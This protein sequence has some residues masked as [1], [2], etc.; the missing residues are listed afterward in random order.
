MH[1]EQVT[2]AVAHH[3]EGPVWISGTRWPDGLYWVDML[4][5]D[6]LSLGPSGRVARRKVGEVVAVV[7]PRVNGGLA[8]AIERGFALD[9]GPGTP[10]RRLPEL[11]SDR[12]VRMNEGGCDP[13][14]FFYAGSMAYD[15]RPA[16]GALYRLALNGTTDLVEGG[17]T[18]PNGL[19][20]AP[21]GRTAYHA[22]TVN[23]RID[24]W[25]WDA[26]AG[27]HHRRPWVRV[28]ANGRPDGLTVDSEGGVW[29]A[30]SGASCVHRYSP[31]GTLSEVIDV[32]AAQVSACA[33]GG[34]AR[35]ELFITTSREGLADPE[36]AAG[37]LFHLHTPV[38]GVAPH[39]YGG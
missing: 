1:A 15:G 9:D 20:W 34:A 27:L 30:I 18:I 38:R 16:A 2:P 31:D 5:G 11:W 6:V 26:E 21:D 3:G 39:P 33:F 17:W 28:D 13:A 22:D 35:D 37:A 32:P 10:L 14:G 12:G 8:Y 25:D 36:P 29:V 4:V 23:R 24:V 19:E 7:R